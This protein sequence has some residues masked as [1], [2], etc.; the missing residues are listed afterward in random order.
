M[1]V[2]RSDTLAFTARE[3]GGAMSKLPYM[4][5]FVDAHFAKT[6]LLSPEQDGALRRIL[7]FLW[8]SDAW[9][10]HDDREIAKIVGVSEIRWT[11]HIKPK[12]WCYF[13]VYEEKF[14]NKRLLNQYGYSKEKSLVKKANGSKGG[15]A[16][17]LKYKN[18]LLANAPANG[19]L[20]AE[21]SASQS[22]GQLTQHVLLDK[23]RQL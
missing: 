12:I 19:Q 13:T 1:V 6:R 22:L 21:A 5:W 2:S 9:A 17:A 23:L 20:N 14:T 3:I 10:R 16:T 11:K 7:D 4:P 18:P 8:I 15:A